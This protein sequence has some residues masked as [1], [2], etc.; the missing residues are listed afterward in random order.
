[1]SDR[2]ESTDESPDSSPTPSDEAEPVT[3]AES[4]S[5]ASE[6]TS[7]TRSRADRSGK[8]GRA[9]H[10][11]DAPSTVTVK[12][13]SI[14]AS[15]AMLL[16]VV[17]LS[18]GGAAGWFG[19]V[20]QAKAQLKADS[21]PAAAGSGAASGPCGAWQQKI[22]AARGEQS[23]ECQQAKGAGELLTPSACDVALAAVPATLAKLKIAR[24]SCEKL[25][26]KLCADLPQGSGTCE[27]VKERTPSFPSQRCDEMLKTYD[28]VLAE[29]KTIDAQGAGQMRG[30]MPR[31]A[32]PPGTMP[33]GH[34]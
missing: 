29:L 11:S 34:P 3:E 15:R 13:S 23:A 26:S 31:G 17:A 10:R 8:A 24:A 30:G 6:T 1:M 20:Q 7:E 33:P 5:K 27:M 19:H 21:V 16:V 22:C 28:Q 25:V 4:P 2:D 32:M 18:A 14:P 9:K 12:P